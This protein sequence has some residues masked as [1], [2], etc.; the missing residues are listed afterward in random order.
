MYIYTHSVVL[1]IIQTFDNFCD[2]ITSFCQ[3]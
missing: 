3:I 2:E 1:K